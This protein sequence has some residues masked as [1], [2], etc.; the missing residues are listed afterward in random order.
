MSG[1]DECKV[2]MKPGPKKIEK[3]RHRTNPSLYYIRAEKFVLTATTVSRFCTTFH[4]I[5]KEP[6]SKRNGWS[7]PYGTECHRGPRSLGQTKK[8]SKEQ[9]INKT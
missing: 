8:N 2:C 9:K 6:L 7:T 4:Q 1:T 3:S 5:A